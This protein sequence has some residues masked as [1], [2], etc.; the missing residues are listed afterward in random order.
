MLAG[1]MRSGYS[2]ATK[3]VVDDE[4]EFRAARQAAI[5]KQAADEDLRDAT[6]AWMRKTFSHGYTY[7]FEW[8]GRPIIQFPQDIMALQEIIWRTKPEVIVETGVARGGSTVFFA[9]M[10]ALLGG[11]R[12]VISIDVEIRPHNRAAIENHPM[13]PLIHLVE[14]SSIDEEVIARVKEDVGT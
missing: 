14:G 11:Q 4:I 10:L 9:S 12:H 7:N 2:R 8:M 5:P 1:A 3:M 6:V 13:A